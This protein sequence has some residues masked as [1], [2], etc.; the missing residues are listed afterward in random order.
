MRLKN[1]EKQPVVVMLTNAG[2]PETGLTVTINA[3]KISDESNVINAQTMNVIGTT[4]I[5]YYAAA[6]MPDLSNE[7]LAIKI[8]GSASLDDADRYKWGVYFYGGTTG[9]VN[10][11]GTLLTD[12]GTLKGNATTII[13]ATDTVESSLTTINTD[14]A[15]DS[16]VAKEST[17][18]ARFDDVDSVLAS[19]SGGAGAVLVNHNYGSANNLQI[20]NSVDSLPVEGS[21]I[22]AYLASDFNAGRLSVEYV[23]AISISNSSGQWANDMHLD[24][25]DYVLL[26]KHDNYQ[27]GTK[28]VTIA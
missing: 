4:G 13:N 7:V 1:S 21:N 17:T 18:Q 28:A 8:D 20:L 23:K 22:Y 5:Y 11:I 14:M 19:I 16:T 25:A 12:T 2:V 24:A 15:K 3:W 27:T 9:W 26:V 6:S 10:D